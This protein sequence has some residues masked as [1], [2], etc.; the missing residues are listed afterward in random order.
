[1]H[2]ARRGSS[3][4]QRIVVVLM[5]GGRCSDCEA[6]PSFPGRGPE[7]SPLDGDCPVI[8]ESPGPG[9]PRDPSASGSRM[10]RGARAEGPSRPS[11]RV[12]APRV[13]SE[14][15]EARTQAGGGPGVTRRSPGGDS[16]PVSARRETAPSPSQRTRRSSFK[17]VREP[18]AVENA[19][20]PIPAFRAAGP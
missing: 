4:G 20:L 5:V 7:S 15:Q 8:S 19:T 9:Q 3:T 11:F 14:S 6:S 18:L 17:L 1:M 10:P 12:P 2:W 13:A 16:E